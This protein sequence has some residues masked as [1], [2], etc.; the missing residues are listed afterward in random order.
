MDEYKEYIYMR[1]PSKWK[2]DAGNLTEQKALR[3][4][5][6][7]KP[8]KW[9]M[10]TV[11]PDLVEF[12]P[13]IEP[14][15]FAK[16]LIKSVANST[17]CFDTMRNRDIVST[18]CSKNVNSPLWTQNFQLSWRKDIRNFDMRCVTVTKN[19]ADAPVNWRRCTNRDN[20]DAV[21]YDNNTKMLIYDRYKKCFQ[22]NG[23]NKVIT[24]NI[25]DEKNENM[26]WEWGFLNET[27]IK[28]W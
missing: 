2:I 3:E 22:I 6:N 13:P 26:K 17:L 1:S 10:E 18:L 5:N 14:I 7:C 20:T 19:K 11:V 16:G 15:P 12:Y 21:K 9:F 23:L 27:R 24:L 25:C 28:D 8:F 4:R